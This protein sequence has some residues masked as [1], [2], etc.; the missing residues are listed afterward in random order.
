VIRVVLALALTTS[1]TASVADAETLGSRPITDR[2]AATLDG[3]IADPEAENDAVVRER[4]ARER[5]S[6][7]PPPPRP[8]EP[9]KIR[10]AIAVNPPLGWS[11]HSVGV[12]AYVAPTKRHVVRVNLAQNWW[13]PNQIPAALLQS[14]MEALYD[15][16]ITDLGASWMFFF[17]RAF[18][19]PSVELGFLHRT[20]HGSRIES[21]EERI[22]STFI[23][24]RALVG[25]NWSIR[26]RVFVSF[27]VGASFGPTTGTKT[28]CSDECSDAGSM[29]EVRRIEWTGGQ[30][31]GFWR[32]GVA[33]DV[34]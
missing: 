5:A 31:E 24:A 21:N 10:A 8:P 3:P 22:D 26:D 13:P 30:I 12:S 28:I 16:S 27:H 32:I 23:A 18:D 7:P 20:T 15:G 4:A 11:E 2:D 17:R 6:R 19:G 33:F 14:E 9:N 29:S 34:I 1:I 25:W